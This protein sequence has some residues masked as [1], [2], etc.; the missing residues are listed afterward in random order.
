[1]NVAL[2]AFAAERRAAVP[3]L[4]GACSWYAARM[5]LSSKPASMDGVEFNAPLD[6]V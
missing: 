2:P 5:A 4:L 1:V 6:T 3:L